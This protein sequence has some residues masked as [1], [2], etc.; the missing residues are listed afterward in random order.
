MSR[1]SIWIF[2]GIGLV[3]L[4]AVAATTLSLGSVTAV[5]DTATAAAGFMG[6]SHH[7]W[8]HRGGGHRIAMVCST[9]RRE[10][11]EHGIE[12]VESFMNFTTPQQQAWASLA[13]AVRAGDDSVGK[14]CAGLKDKGKPQSATDKLALAETMLSTGLEVVTKVRPAFDQFYGT[15]NSKQQKALDN[16]MSRRH[17]N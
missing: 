10:K 6:G 5:A 8:R 12:F 11:V 1:K 15:L 4:G 14:A 2:S 9:M 13:S 3:A 7:G 17:R 16:L